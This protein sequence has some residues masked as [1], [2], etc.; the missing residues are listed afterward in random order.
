MLRGCGGPKFVRDFNVIC[1]GELNS[2]C[3]NICIPSDL[4]RGSL[5]P[6]RY[7]IEKEFVLDTSLLNARAVS[8]VLGGQ[9]GAVEKR[10]RLPFTL[11]RVLKG[12][13]WRRWLSSSTASRGKNL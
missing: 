11:E 12:A 1:W 4:Q 13:S 9:S 2:P 10:N 8:R 6:V 3:A 5:S 7:P